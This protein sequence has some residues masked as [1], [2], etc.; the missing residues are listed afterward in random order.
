MSKQPRLL[1]IT[2]NIALLQWHYD[3]IIAALASAG[4]HLSIRYAKEKW[5]TADEYR[6]MLERGGAQVSVRALP[7]AAED[8]GETLALR[9]RRLGNVL[10]YTH[11]DY[12]RRTALRV[13]AFEGAEPDVQRWA[14][15]I[16]RLGPRAAS[17]IAWLLARAEST[18]PPSRSAYAVLVEEDPDAVVALPIIREPSF[19][20]FLKAGARRGIPTVVWIPSWDNLTNKGLLHFIPDRVFVWNRQQADELARYHRVPTERVSVTGAQTFDHWFSGYAS[21]PRAEFC[22]RLGIDRNRPL[23]LY[24]ASSLQTAPNE[25]EFFG[26]WLRSVR[27]SND[28]VLESAAVLV[29][30]HWSVVQS[31]LERDFEREAGVAVSRSTD[32]HPLFSDAYR[33][34]YGDELH[35]ATVAVGINTSAMIEAAIFGKPVCTVELPELFHS[36]RGTVHFQYLAN[37]GGGLLRTASSLEEHVAVLSELIRRDP[38]ARDERS[39]EFVRAFVRPHG[40]DVTPTEIF[41]EEM[42]KCLAPRR[43][44]N[45]SRGVRPLRRRLAN[46]P[47]AR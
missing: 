40:T 38:Y 14:R 9:L 5:L 29:R 19:V 10:R 18:F 30:P 34:E 15:R 26:R 47:G 6:A 32:R 2:S 42:V 35:H 16:A 12:A 27:S 1:V 36:Q 45:S 25:L 20:D 39:T 43:D 31:W 8:R 17:A 23:I 13:R 44:P 24:L 21:S 28:P 37:G 7:A 46:R 41:C 22:S 4:V 3:G 11:P 33:Q